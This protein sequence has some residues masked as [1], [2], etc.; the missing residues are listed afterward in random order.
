MTA[1]DW[2]RFTARVEVPVANDTLAWEW[3]IALPYRCLADPEQGLV[4]P[5]SPTTIRDDFENYD[6]RFRQRLAYY[7]S[8]Q[9]FLTYSFGWTRH[10]KGLLWWYDAGWPTTDARFALLKDIWFYDQTLTGYLAWSTTVDPEQAVRPLRQWATKTDLTPI[11]VPNTWSDKLRAALS[12][13]DWTG[14]SDPMHLGGGWHGGAASGFLDGGD[15][16]EMASARLI[17]VD[18]ESRSA[19]F[20]ADG[21]NGWYASLSD[22]A[23]Q[24]PPLKNGRNWHIEVYVRPIGFLGVYRRSHQTGLWFSGQ[25][26]YHSVGN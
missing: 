24:L 11:E 25:H 10:D 3:A 12:E 8:L 15:A 23:Q 2:R 14:G 19:T 17:G 22:L 4:M 26:R 21:I 18:A 1:A 7:T 9:S 5:A 13:S 20:I 6:R 16:N